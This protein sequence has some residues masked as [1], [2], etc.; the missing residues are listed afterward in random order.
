MISQHLA[1]QPLT[2]FPSASSLLMFILPPQERFSGNLSFQCAQ[3][4]K[5]LPVVVRTV[6]SPQIS[7]SIFGNEIWGDSGGCTTGLPAS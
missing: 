3:E 7:Y 5:G 2:I 1:V 6:S 4:A